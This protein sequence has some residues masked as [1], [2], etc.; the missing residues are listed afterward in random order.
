MITPNSLSKAN[1][2]NRKQRMTALIQTQAI[3]IRKNILGS[4][5]PTSVATQ[6]RSLVQD[7]Y[8]NT[9]NRRPIYQRP[10]RWR[11]DAYNDLIGTIMNNGVVPGLYMYRLHPEDKVDQEQGKYNYEVVDG[12]HRLYGIK[13]FVEST[14]QSLPHIKKPFVVHWDHEKA[15]ENGNK[16]VVRVFYKKTPD[17]EEY[18][19]MTYKEGSPE[20]LTKDEKDD[21]DDFTIGITMFRS[22]MSMDDRR[23]EF[24]TLQKGVPVRNS[25]Y[26]KN[27]TKCKLM[28]AFAEHDHEQMMSVLLEHCTKKA[29]NFWIQWDTRL[30]LLWARA[31]NAHSTIQPSTIFVK[32]DPFIKVMINSNAPDLDNFTP[33]QF[34]EYHLMFETFIELLKSGGFK[35]NPT[36]L[37]ALFYHLCSG[38]R[39]LDIIKTNMPT[40]VFAEE[41][42]EKYN[43][44]MWE[45]DKKELRQQYFDVCL[46]DL[47]DMDIAVKAP[48]VV[49]PRKNTSKFRPEVFDK[50][51]EEGTCAICEETEITLENCILGHIVAH[52]KGGTETLDNLLPMCK[53]C[54]DGMRMRHALKYKKVM[55]PHTVK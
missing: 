11:P 28:I 15:D 19:R 41:G 27:Q 54:N 1:K 55:Y 9:I 53:P 16:K 2:S 51:R 20:Y 30:F 40:S 33:E 36:Q 39:A 42:K 14:Y 22:K 23:G 38:R 37:F 44:K 46:L 31:K 8:Y 7:E 4:V 32:T 18:Y 45:S 43:K 48:I 24:M 6:I 35:L 21:F 52:E 25:D 50:R 26:L 29:S 3:R 49:N 10:M 47:V 13:S 5:P 17:V 34:V 12:Q